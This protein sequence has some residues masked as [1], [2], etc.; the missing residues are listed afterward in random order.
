MA[1]SIEEYKRR[2]DE[3][4]TE[5]NGLMWNLS[6]E[7]LKELKETQLKLRELVEKAAKDI[8]KQRAQRDSA[9]TAAKIVSAK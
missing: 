5:L 9:D 4:I 2:W 1:V 3:H 7:E 6:L 8:E